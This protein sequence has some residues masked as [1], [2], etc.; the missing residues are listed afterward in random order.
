MLKTQSRQLLILASLQMLLFGYFAPLL[1]FNLDNWAILQVLM[2]A[3]DQS[4]GGLLKAFHSPFYYIRPGELIYFPVL[5]WAFG[6]AAW[7]YHCA[8]FAM[9]L[10]AAL[11]IF[12]A[13]DRATPHRALAFLTAALYIA[14]PSHASTHN[15]DNSSFAS[16]MTFYAASLFFYSVW[17]D[18]KSRMSLLAS[19]GLFAFGALL[20]EAVL[21]LAVMFPL[22]SLLHNRKNIVRESAPFVFA[23]LVLFIYHVAIQRLCP[24]ALPRRLQFD[25]YFMLKVLGRGIECSFTSIPDYLRRSIGPA[26]HDLPFFLWIVGAVSVLALAVCLPEDCIRDQDLDSRTT[27]V[28]LAGALLTFVAAYAPYAVSADKYVPHI[29]DVQNRVNGAA[30]LPASMFV[31]WLVLKLPLRL[32]RAALASLLGAFTIISWRTGRDWSQSWA[33]EKRILEGVRRQAS[34]IPPGP[35]VIYL[36]GAPDHI[37]LAPVFDQPWVFDS[38]VQDATRNWDLRGD[39][40]DQPALGKEIM[41]T[42]TRWIYRFE[43]EELSR[44]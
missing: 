18:K 6:L 19:L 20:Y 37:G 41:A 5:Y 15:Y 7:K 44:L 26:I 38:A 34:Q 1:G 9:E 8:Y 40:F 2:K 3:P 11:L 28:W 30:S 12:R 33:M 21:P 43:K 27:K 25:A 32:R 23:A 42:R 31:A 13:F 36:E 29:F 35:A 39:L 4:L 17:I 22:L 24:Q 14:Y 10:A 16:V